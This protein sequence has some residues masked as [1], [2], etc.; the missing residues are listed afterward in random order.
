MKP[1]T[2]VYQVFLFE[3]RYTSKQVI[4]NRPVNSP[5]GLFTIH[6]VHLKIP[7]TR[8]WSCFLKKTPDL[9]LNI[10]LGSGLSLLNRWAR[11]TLRVQST[12]PVHIT[13]PSP[14]S[15]YD[16][17][18]QRP[19]FEIRKLAE[20]SSPFTDK[21][22]ST[23]SFYESVSGVSLLKCVHFKSEWNFLGVLI[24]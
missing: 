19:L 15:E 9:F 4:H 11:I 6:R 20:L 17:L 23:L 18:T 12:S 16:T 7:L 22:T 8:T 14:S 10:K 24:V 13:C 3:I 5:R 21:W 2:Q 1:C